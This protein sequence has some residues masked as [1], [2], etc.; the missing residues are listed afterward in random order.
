MTDMQCDPALGFTAARGGAHLVLHHVGQVDVKPG[1]V[2]AQGQAPGARAQPAACEW[3]S[4]TVGR[5]RADRG[6][7]CHA[8]V[9]SH[10]S[11]CEFGAPPPSA[12]RAFKPLAQVHHL[13]AGR[14]ADARQVAPQRVHRV[15][16]LVVEEAVLEK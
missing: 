7:A 16:Q 5:E 10:T 2:G 8:R 13:D 15:Q 9:H 11:R 3:I 6:A 4:Q 1:H 14:G 12:P